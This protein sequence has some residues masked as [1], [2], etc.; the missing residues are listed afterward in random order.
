M[1]TYEELATVPMKAEQ[2]AA[3]DIPEPE[4]L[5]KKRS[6]DKNNEAN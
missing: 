3:A 6:D 5:R 2:V 1:W 4:L